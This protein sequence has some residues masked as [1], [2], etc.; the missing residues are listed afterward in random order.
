MVL[1]IDLAALTYAAALAVSFAILAYMA[2]AEERARR[3]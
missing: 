3:V 1:G 2:R